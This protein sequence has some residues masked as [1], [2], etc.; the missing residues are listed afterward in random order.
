MTIGK[1]IRALRE[2]RDLTQDQLAELLD[3][4]QK[5][6]SS[7]EIDRTEP[8]MGM[9]ERICMVLNCQKTDIIENTNYAIQLSSIESEIMDVTFKLTDENKKTLLKQAKFLLYE[10]EEE[11][12]EKGNG[13]Q[14][15]KEA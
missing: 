4:S 10:Q 9:I 12:K 13:S 8:K 11:F 15:S 5:T 2:R 3:V 7:W 14:S 1:N 6:V